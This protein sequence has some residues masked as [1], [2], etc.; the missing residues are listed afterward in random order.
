LTEKGHV[1]NAIM[2]KNMIGMAIFGK[3]ES[4]FLGVLQ[5][6]NKLRSST[7]LEVCLLESATGLTFAWTNFFK[8]FI[9]RKLFWSKIYLLSFLGNRI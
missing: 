6:A 7:L 8:V 3:N 2:P 9:Y 4:K 5:E 1:L